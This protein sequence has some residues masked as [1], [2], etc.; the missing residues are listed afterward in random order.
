MWKFTLSLLGLVVIS[1]QSYA[2]SG[3]LNSQGCHAG[4]RPYHCHRAASEM[5]ETNAGRNRL[6][7]DLGSRSQECSG[8]YRYQ[9]PAPQFYQL[10]Q[11]GSPPGSVWSV[12]PRNNTQAYP[13]SI[14]IVL[15]QDLLLMHCT[16]LPR[17]I[18]T[19]Q[20]DPTTQFIL[21]AFQK[22]HGVAPTGAYD[23]VTAP[24]LWSRPTGNCR[25]QV[26]R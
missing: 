18:A 11:I 7:C 21:Q 8:N 9:A 5:V 24:L 12:T 15:L 1:S 26:R 14:S 6:R 10:P 2:H 13:A 23:H 22:A 17:E 19:G 16:G 3:G 4:S 20:F 25:F